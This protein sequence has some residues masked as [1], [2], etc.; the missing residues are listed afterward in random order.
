MLTLWRPYRDWLSW[1]REIDDVFG[2]ESDGT[3][4]AFCP[5]VD[6]EEQQDAFVLRADLPGVSEKDV[7]LTVHDGV[8]LISG[9][10]EQA[11]KEEKNGSLV[12]ERRY[13]TFQRQFQLGRGVDATRIEA[14]CKNGVLT[15]V[16]PKAESAKPRQIPVKAN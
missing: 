16:L 15:V 7:T 5:A 9:K 14:S 11:K 10:R 2:K 13:G 6:I 4:V 3:A 8:L 12:C 1:S